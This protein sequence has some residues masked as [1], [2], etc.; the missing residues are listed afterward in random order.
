MSSGP[1]TAVGAGIYGAGATPKV[2]YPKGSDG[3][4]PP[5]HA[6]MII[7]ACSDYRLSLLNF[8]HTQR[9]MSLTD[10]LK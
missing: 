6:G 4:A 9:G 8:L 3:A 5:S 10:R 1:Q 2:G 7:R